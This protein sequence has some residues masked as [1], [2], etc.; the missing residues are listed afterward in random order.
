MISV[1]FTDIHFILLGIFCVSTL[2]LLW[3]YFFYFSRVSF[4]KGKQ[5]DPSTEMLPPVSV[6]IC[7]R[8]ED[9]NL[10]EF[11]PL[12]LNQDYPEFE[13]VV[14]N[15]CSW[16][17]T[18]DVLREFEKK[19]KRLKVIT[20]KEDPNHHHGKKFAIMVGIKGVTYE[21][22]LLTD[23]DCRVLSNQ[24]IRKMARNFSKEKTIVLGYSKFEKHP[25]LLNRIIRFDTFHIA[26]QY[27]SFA[28]AGKPYMGV[29]RNLAYTRTLFF[30]NKGFAS[31]YHIESGDD[32]LFINEVA[33]GKN[34]A[35]E[36]DPESFTESRVKKDYKG[37]VQQKRRHLTTWTSYRLGDKLRLGV[38]PFSQV[39]FWFAFL[40]LF[41]FWN[42]PLFSEY[43]PYIVLGIFG[44]HFI[45]KFLVFK[46]AMNKL[47]ESDLFLT[48]LIAGPFLLVFYPVLSMTNRLY[49]RQKWKRI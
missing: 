37:W 2:V 47:K 35:I 40:S 13:V 39:L 41:F 8:N 49:R 30:N 23:G 20:I 10:P 38:Y 36:T 22:I 43:D 27:L 21:Q 7:A 28:R 34:T 44:L 42:D 29:G 26:M 24:W 31:H 32:D 17:N 4:Y 48:S 18:Q 46:L 16:D 11:L 3:Y 45:S 19:Y 9:H 1:S 14:V 5:A 33:A 12:I 15:D 25:G 6:L